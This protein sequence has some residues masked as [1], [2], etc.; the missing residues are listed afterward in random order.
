M[1]NLYSGGNRAMLRPVTIWLLVS[2]GFCMS[3][4]LL[5]PGHYS[6]DSGYQY[7]QARTG[8]ISNVTPVAMIGL[9]SVLLAVFGNPASLLCLNLGMFWAGLGLCFFSRI[10]PLGWTLIGIVICGL[11]PLVLMQMAHLLSDAHLAA[12]LVLATGLL[13]S[14]QPYKGRA[15][16][17][18]ACVLIVYAGCIRQNALVA[19]VPLGVV[20]AWMLFPTSNRRYRIVV[21][22]ALATTLVTLATS[23]AFDR[24]LAVERR[25]LWPMLALWDLAAMSVATNDLLLPRFTHGPGLSV[26]E[27]RE[28][29]GYDPVSAAPLFAR[30]RSGMDSGLERPYSEEQQ[31]E[32]AVA[33]WSGVRDHP[34]EY[35]AHRLNTTALLFGRHDERTVGLAYYP[36]RSGYRDNPALPATWNPSAHQALIDLAGRLRST[37]LFGALP[38]VLAHLTLLILACCRRRDPRAAIV[39][40][41][42]CSSLVYAASFTVL[43]PS[44]ELRFMTWPIV[45]APLALLLWFAPIK[46]HLKEGRK[47]GPDKPGLAQPFG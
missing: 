10:L 14:H 47:H 40:G 43:A 25:S 38:Y 4:A 45:A 36:A 1:Q 18:I 2:L 22:G 39:L 28:T 6:F 5:Y 29:K 13:A 37:W 32:L 12:V 7:W 19:G 15:S 16:I 24:T 44:V 21:V 9:W 3:L 27:L 8:E 20:A 31:K 17:W 11:S 41:V 30:T 34:R 42:T 23:I 35:L 33:W 46:A 26:D